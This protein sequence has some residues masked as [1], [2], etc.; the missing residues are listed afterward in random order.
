M[1]WTREFDEAMTPHST[2][3]VYANYL[4][5]DDDARVDAAYGD[6]LERLADLKAAYDP[7]NLFSRARDVRPR[8]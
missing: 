1:A 3:G 6:N 2:G 5:R 8:E 4:D 7:E